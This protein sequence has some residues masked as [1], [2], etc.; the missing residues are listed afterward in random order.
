M[1]ESFSFIRAADAF[2]VSQGTELN[3]NY[4]EFALN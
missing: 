1:I 4:G 3:K 2:A